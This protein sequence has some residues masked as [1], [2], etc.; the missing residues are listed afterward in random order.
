MGFNQE[1]GEGIHQ[2]ET[3]FQQ[4]LRLRLWLTACLID[5]QA[6]FSQASEPLVTHREVACVIPHVAHV[7]DSDFDVDTAHPVASHEELTDTTFALVTYRVQVAGRL[8][9]FGPECSTSAERHK[10]AQEVQQQIFTLLHYCDPESS[11]YAWFTWHS[12]QSIIS[13]VRLSELLPF[14]CGQPGSHISLPLSREGDSTL[15]SR[16]LQNLEKAQLIRDDPRG[17]GFRWYI[18]TPW[19]ALSTAISQCNSCTNVALVRRAW[20]V[21]ETSYRQHE[22]FLNSHQSQPQGLMAQLMNETREKLAPLLQEDVVGFSDSQTVDRVAINS[23]QAP[24]P[25]GIIPID[26]LL[27]GGSLR[28]DSEASSIGSLPPFGQQSW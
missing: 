5:L 1:P 25:L 23:L 3:F 19:L 4:Q 7:N 20:P 21:I 27:T 16:A 26:P 18:T 6:S 13:A 15:L 10:L 17:D 2:G 22:T 14:R 12:T 9:N 8:L 28:A 11:S 24:V